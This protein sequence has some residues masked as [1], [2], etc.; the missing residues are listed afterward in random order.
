MASLALMVEYVAVT[1]EQMVDI[2]GVELCVQTFGDRSDPAILLI[3]GATCSMD[4]WDEGFCRQLADNNRWVIRYDLR[5]T[6][7]STTSPAGSPD[8]TLEDLTGD[9][10]ALVESLQLE[11]CH[12]VGISMGGMIGQRFALQ[13]PDLLASLTLIATTPGQPGEPDLPP[14]A[15]RL[16]A[17]FAK[18]YPA[19]DW[20][21]RDSVNDYLVRSQAVMAGP[22]SFDEAWTR[23]ISGQC[24]DRS[25]SLAASQNHPL[26]L[27]AESPRSRLG[28]ITL[29]TQIMHGTEDP[30]FPYGHAE[31][32]NAEIAGSTLIPLDGMGHQPPPPQVWHVVIPAILRHS[33]GDAADRPAQR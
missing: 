2:N 11:S 12:L 29:P 4:W 17:Y 18:Q 31:A 33:H 10:I 14:V 5:D 8:Y 28:E 27:A 9:A 1:A 23:R 6:G 25:I 16:Q 24:F 7:R 32:L 26:L 19:P 21:D 13:R 3:A 30:L 20:Q 15:D 22:A